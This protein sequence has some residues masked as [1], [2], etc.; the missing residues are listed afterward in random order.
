MLTMYVPKDLYATADTFQALQIVANATTAIPFLSLE[1]PKFCSYYLS[2]IPV[3][4]RIL[5]IQFLPFHQ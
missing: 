1:L 3:P 4:T 5:S 2:A